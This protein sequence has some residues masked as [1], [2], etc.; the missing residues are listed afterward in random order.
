MQNWKWGYP[1][2]ASTVSSWLQN[3]LM[4]NHR[5]LI[6][7]YII[8]KNKNASKN[9]EHDRKGFKEKYFELKRNRI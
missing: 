4:E 3:A 5:S 2:K 6:Q 1:Q 7:M 8:M 9:C